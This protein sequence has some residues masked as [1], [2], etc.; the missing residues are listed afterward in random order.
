VAAVAWV[1]D[2]VLALDAR[3]AAPVADPAP[4]WCEAPARPTVGRTR[5]DDDGAPEADPADTDGVPD[6][7]AAFAA[8]VDDAA[9]V[10][11]DDV[12]E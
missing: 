3:R 11:P 10:E 5:P 1:V 9:G 4:D 12:P 2:A 7:E 6:C 8:G